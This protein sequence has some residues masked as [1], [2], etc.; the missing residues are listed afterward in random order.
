[1]NAHAITRMRMYE[2]EKKKS[3]KGFQRICE[4]K[5][6]KITESVSESERESI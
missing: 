5:K 2:Y 1:M 4:K 3:T 6:K